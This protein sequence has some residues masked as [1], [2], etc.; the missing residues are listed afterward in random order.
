MMN[1]IGMYGYPGT[2]YGR[3]VS[4]IFFLRTNTADAPSA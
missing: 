3:G 4:G 1:A 2:R